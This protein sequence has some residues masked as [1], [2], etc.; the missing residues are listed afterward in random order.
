M[1]KPVSTEPRLSAGRATDGRVA[2]LLRYSDGM[3]RR[4]IADALDLPLPTVVS[5]VGRLV[6][7]GELDEVAGGVPAEGG[8]TRLGRPAQL[9]RWAQFRPVLGFVAVSGQAV[10]AAIIDWSGTTLREET[11]D[12]GRLPN[13]LADLESGFA[14]LRGSTAAGDAAERRPERLGAVVLSVPAPFQP[15]AGAPTSGVDGDPR[16]GFAPW[17][18]GDPTPLFAERFGVPVVVENNANLAALGEYLADTVPNADD[19]VYLR[20]AGSWVSAGLVLGGRIQRGAVGF[21]G[22]LGHVHVDDDGPLCRCGGRGCLVTRIGPLL[23]DARS[24]YDP[25]VDMPDLL[26]LAAA[27]EPGPARALV[28]LGRLIGRP[29][30]DLCTVLNPDAVVVGGEIGASSD[31]VADGIRE[32]IDRYAPPVVRTS[33]TTVTSTLGVRAERLGAVG[34]VRAAYAS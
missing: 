1:K 18:A 34:A 16:L 28:D 24:L 9:V 2:A 10:T 3:T 14:F 33:V 17:L 5:A 32:Q 12:L 20:I 30:A 21:A 23:A 26:R 22:E 29:L 15:G 27:G 13:R 7:A 6:Q 31:L 11:V 8:A 4:A 25:P 19:V